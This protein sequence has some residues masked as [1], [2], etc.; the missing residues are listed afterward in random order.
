[1]AAERPTYHEERVIN[2][3]VKL[4][5]KVVATDLWRVDHA[6]LDHLATEIL[7][8][9][10]YDQPMARLS[11]IADAPV[12]VTIRPDGEGF[13]QYPAL[14]SREDTH[15]DCLSLCYKVAEDRDFQIWLSEISSTTGCRILPHL[16]VGR[17]PKYFLL[18]GMLH[19]WL[20]LL[21]EKTM[22]RLVVDPSFQTISLGEGYRAT[23]EATRPIGSDFSL[24][25]CGNVKLPAGKYFRLESGRVMF[26]DEDCGFA[27]LGMTPNRKIIEL[28]FARGETKNDPVMALARLVGADGTIDTYYI[29]PVMGLVHQL[30]FKAPPESDRQALNEFYKLAARFYFYFAQY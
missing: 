8:K 15:G 5:A 24:P 30:S 26:S 6:L 21:H 29:D 2:P 4:A 10:R 20:T 19:Y 27:V 17:P 11:A 16:S 13:V 23:P 14:L 7:T 12:T 18:N 28:G 22:T 1:M 25:R 3:E 9:Y